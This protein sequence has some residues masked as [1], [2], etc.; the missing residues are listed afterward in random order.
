M[1]VKVKCYSGYIYAQ[2]P[3]SF[4]W[5]ALR[6]RLFKVGTEK[7]KLFEMCHIEERYGSPHSVTTSRT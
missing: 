4:I 3:Q 1:E 5:Q 7:D 2:E 6:K